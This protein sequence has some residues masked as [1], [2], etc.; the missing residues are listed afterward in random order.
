LNDG[1]TANDFNSRYPDNGFVDII[2]LDTYQ[3]P[4]TTSSQYVAKMQTQI[5]TIV[6]WADTHNKIAA[7]TEMGCNNLAN[8]NNATYT[9]WFTQTM[10]PALL[11]QRIAYSMLWRNPKGDALGDG[12][13]APRKK[14]CI[15]K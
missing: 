9:N 10:K 5:A 15:Y 14:I 2:G 6:Q 8:A 13:K 11:G 4:G 12:T 3:R 1:F 7:V